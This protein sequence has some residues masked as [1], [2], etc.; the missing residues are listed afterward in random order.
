VGLVRSDDVERFWTD[1]DP[2]RSRMLEAIEPFVEEVGLDTTHQVVDE[3][4]F[5]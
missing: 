4:A 5:V 3:P 1:A 2:V